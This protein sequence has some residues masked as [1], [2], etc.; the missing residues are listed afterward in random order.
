MVVL[1]KIKYYVKYRETQS[2]V[3]LVKSVVIYEN[4]PTPMITEPMSD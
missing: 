1:E 4:Q 3:S 2:L